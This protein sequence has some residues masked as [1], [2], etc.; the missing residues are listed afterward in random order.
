MRAR[1]NSHRDHGAQVEDAGRGQITGRPDGAVVQF[2]RRLC[3][4]LFARCP[5]LRR[6]WGWVII[7]LL[8]TSLGVSLSF[9]DYS[10]QLDVFGL[11]PPHP[12]LSD[13]TRAC[14]SEQ[15]ANPFVRHSFSDLKIASHEEKMTFRLSLPFLGHVLGL[16]LR[17]PHS[18]A[19]IV[20][21]ALSWLGLQ[22]RLACHR[23]F[24]L[25]G[26]AAFWLHCHPTGM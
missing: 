18:T 9:P 13:V 10:H 14:L 22:A 15:I 17:A 2:I 12:H 4:M 6:R 8:A 20:R 26:L 11:A 24:C 1:S 21:C 5:A 3:E 7:A 23:R 19:A 16:R 25:R